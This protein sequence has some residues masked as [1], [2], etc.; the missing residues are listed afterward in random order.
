MLWYDKDSDRKKGTLSW[1]DFV[2]AMK[3]I[4]FRHNS[5]RSGSRHGFEPD[6]VQLGTKTRIVLHGTHGSGDQSKIRWT[7]AR[8]IG[9]SLTDVYG[10]TL[11]NF[12]IEPK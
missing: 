12:A 4:G 7:K 2:S 9:K 10:W 8:G 5:G 3:T 1:D 11:E 6:P